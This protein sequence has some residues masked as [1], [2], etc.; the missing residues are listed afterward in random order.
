MLAIVASG[1]RLMSVVSRNPV[2]HLAAAL[3]CALIGAGWLATPVRAGTISR[4]LQRATGDTPSALTT[5]P[6][7]G[8]SSPGQM[9]CLAQVLTLRGTGR[10]ATPL[11]VPH[12]ASSETQ[13]LSDYTPAFLQSAYDTTWL[14]AHEGAGDTVAIIDAYDDPDAASDMAEFR[15]ASGLPACPVG[16]CFSQYNQSGALI[17]GSGSGRAPRE[18]RT[19]GWE[20]EESLDLDAVSSICP[21]CKIDLIEANS[22]SDASLEAAVA[23]AHEVGANQISMSFGGE[24]APGSDPDGGKWAFAGE[25]SL[26]AVGDASYQGPGYVEYPAAY[27]D[28][29]SV[30]GTSLSSDSTA[31]RGFG[32]SAWVK[33]TCRGGSTCGTESGCDTSEATPNWQPSAATSA[34]DAIEHDL[35]ESQTGGRAYNDISADADP[36]TGLYVYDTIGGSQGCSTWCIVGGTSLATPLAAAFEA[37]TA[38]SGT[39]SPEWTYDDASLLNDIVSGSDGSCPA[40]A[41]LLCDAI[42]GWDGPTGNGSISGDLVTGGPGIGGSAAT[43]ASDT[44]ETLSGGVYPNGLD[45]TCTWQIWTTDADGNATTPL[46][47]SCGTLSGPSLQP[48]STTVAGLTSATTYYYDLALSNADGDETG[49]QGS[50][51]TSAGPADSSG[52]GSGSNGGSSS[53]SGSGSNGGSGSSGGSGSNG[54]SGGT[55]T[56]T[57]TTTTTSAT[58]GGYSESGGT[59]TGGTQTGGATTTS[60]S[61]RFYRCT[62]T[63]V[64]IRTRGASSYRPTKADYGRYIKVVTKLTRTTATGATT[65]SVSTRWIGPVTASK[66]GDIS[67]GTGARV[68]STSVIRGSTHRTLARVRILR[69]RGNTLTLSVMRSGKAATRTWAYVVSKGAVIS[70]TAPR[71]LRHS[72]TVRLTLRRGQ[73]LKLVAVRA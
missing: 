67:I 16:T 34:C 22:T 57:T 68:A 41:A 71:A 44:S 29:T 28:V 43:Y 33:Q 9:H 38:V 37:V 49:Y 70:G 46:S 30:G 60:T 69:R 21:L 17:D 48:V 26:A 39:D 56:T 40:G 24:E 51:V 61:V 31:T 1:V 36:N 58:N 3:V 7:C 6:V 73:T 52:G 14:S 72:A 5:K 18:D 62:H 27:P 13:T 35:G 11:H 54:G 12:A 15:S 45:T 25:A 20:L 47:V 23:V 53:N 4:A 66:A 10:P 50:F 19:G 2:R 42:A 32:E 65:S 55:T 63:C 8:T 64:L 59:H